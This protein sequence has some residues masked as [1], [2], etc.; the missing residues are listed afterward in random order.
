MAV[1]LIALD[2]DGTTLNSRGRIT[3]FTA[4][5]LKEAAEKGIHVVIATGRPRVALPQQVLSVEGIQYAVTSNGAAVID[6]HRDSIIYENYIEEKAM[7]DIYRLL[8]SQPF[9]TEIFVKGKA[10]VEKTIFE[11]LE[12]MGFS[13]GHIE[14]VRTTRKPYE[15][16]LDFMLENSGKVENINVCFETMEEKEYMREHLLKLDNVTVTSSSLNNLEI[17][18]RS[19]SKAAALLAMCE[20]FGIDSSEMMACG[21]SP[22]DE[23]MLSAAGISVAMGNALP[24]VKRKSKYVT[25]T[26]DEDGVAHAIRKFALV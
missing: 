12:K 24:S 11:N 26:N 19:T 10:Y 22:N 20:K 5:T 2:L 3:D 18:G 13:K 16:V 1:K 4:K 8:S 25:K 9:M 23:E 7:E 21:D 14:Y 17:N 6:L 15:G